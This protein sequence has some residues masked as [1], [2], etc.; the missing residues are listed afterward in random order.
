MFPVTD[1]PL[2]ECLLYLNGPPSR[3]TIPLKLSRQTFFQVLKLNFLQI[4]I[5]F[6][7]QTFFSVKSFDAVSESVSD[8]DDELINVRRAEDDIIPDDEKVFL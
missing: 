6:N 8:D 5:F 4:K 2:T 3:M 1:G 7:F